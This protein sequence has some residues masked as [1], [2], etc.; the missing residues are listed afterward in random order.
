M[1]TFAA[2]VPAPNSLSGL[3]ISDDGTSLFVS[4]W[5]GGRVLEL[6]AYTGAQRHVYTRL[7]ENY[8]KL[9]YLRPDAH[10]M[11]ILGTAYALDLESGELLPGRLLFTGQNNGASFAVSDT[12]RLLY[13]QNSGISG[14]TLARFRIGYS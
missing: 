6:D 2:V 9:F 12:Q 3:T 13:A 1:T 14:S 4:E 11:L 8:S 7:H 5:T 10:A